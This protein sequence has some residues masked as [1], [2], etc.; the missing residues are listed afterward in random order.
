MDYV[1]E[2]TK[3][4]EAMAKETQIY[5]I[6][7]KFG[8]KLP[9]EVKDELYEMANSQKKAYNSIRKRMGID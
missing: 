9:D 3:L 5:E 7:G 6:L 4:N 1:K 8:N 2:A